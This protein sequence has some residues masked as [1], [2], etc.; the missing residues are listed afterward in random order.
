[1]IL[2]LNYCADMFRP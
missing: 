1:M 2:F